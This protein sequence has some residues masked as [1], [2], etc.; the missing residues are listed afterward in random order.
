M[1]TNR[2]GFL[3]FVLSAITGRFSPAKVAAPMIVPGI[4]TI[5]TGV[6]DFVPT[7]YPWE[8]PGG[9]WTSDGIHPGPAGVR[10]MHEEM[11]TKLVDT[12]IF[13]IVWFEGS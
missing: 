1:R 7:P 6:N 10:I 11:I 13:P 5:A 12:T 2:R 4:T 3:S 8:W 9:G